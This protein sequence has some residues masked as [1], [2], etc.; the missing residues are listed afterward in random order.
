MAECGDNVEAAA[1]YIMSHLDEPEEFWFAETSAA[2]AP[3]GREYP[4]DDAGEHAAALQPVLD[5]VRCPD[6]GATVH[7]EECMWSFARP[8][9]Q[10]GTWRGLVAVATQLPAACRLRCATAA[11]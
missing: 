10:D 7:K 2:A 8:T 6:D 5:R 4:P 3:A 9:S 11:T 1:N